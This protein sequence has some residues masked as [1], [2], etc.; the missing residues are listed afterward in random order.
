MNSKIGIIRTTHNLSL[1][2][3]A[4]KTGVTVED[5]EKL[6]S[7]EEMPDEN[8]IS[9]ICEAF[10]V[11]R[12][13]MT[14]DVQDDESEEEE[15]EIEG[16]DPFTSALEENPVESAM[17]GVK[18]AAE[19]ISEKIRQSIQES[20]PVFSEIGE[21][22]RKAT[23]DARPAFDEIGE[24]IKKAAEDARPAFNEISDRI[25]KS[26]EDARPAFDEIGER[27]RKAA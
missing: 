19:E 17:E 15:D 12:E 24:R 13:W 11:S 21:R 4:D 3:F 27:I 9:R 18:P 26:V 14:S 25:R 20:G 6:E 7:G 16:E 10:E 22:I 8:T 23:E 5:L 1:E 2:E